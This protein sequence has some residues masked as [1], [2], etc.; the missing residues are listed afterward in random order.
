LEKPG[1]GE[2]STLGNRNLVEED[3]RLGA[4]ESFGIQHG[5]GA[6]S[7]FLDRLSSAFRDD[8]TQP[9]EMS[10]E[11]VRLFEVFQQQRE[12]FR[13]RLMDELA[14]DLANL[15]EQGLEPPRYPT[16]IVADEYQDFTAGELRLLALFKDKLGTVVAAAG[17][18]RQSIFGFRAADPLALHRFPEAYRLS[19][20]DYLPKSKRCPDA[21]CRFAEAISSDLPELPGIDRPPLS[22]WPGREDPGSVRVVV[23]PSPIGEARWIVSECRTLVEQG[24][25]PKDI[26]IVVSRFISEASA[27]LKRAAGEQEELPFSFY[28]PR[29]ADPASNDLAT[30]LASAAARL[31]V[32]GGDQMAWR[33]FVWATPQLGDAR[34]TRIL[35]VG[36]TDY[37]R[38]LRRVAAGDQ[39]CAR[40][41]TAGETVIEKYGSEEEFPALTAVEEIAS[42]LRVQDLDLTVLAGIVEDLAEEHS[43]SDWLERI[44]EVSQKTQ[45]DPEERPTDIAVRTIFSAKGLEAPVVFVTNVVQQ[46][47][48]GRGSVADG[49]RR[50][51][52][53]VTRPTERLYVS[54]PRYLGFSRMGHA[55]GSQTGGV[56]GA[57]TRAAERCE[58]TVELL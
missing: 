10:P 45:I 43:A 27:E 36:E 2:L 37:L 4:N 14:Y 32:D 29:V 46:S 9:A 19:E 13:Y 58:L 22:P 39:T 35:S 1:V 53:A 57:V 24:V 55:V 8:Q 44:F 34:K 51:Y 12:L 30:R 26:M 42:T 16:H 18:D 41:L 47:L 6:V 38:N 11:E 3:L 54:A 5:V 56:A 20:V 33:T 21:V 7:D 17:D 31:V 40:P 48:S 25:K 15:I 49:L 50:L 28:D 52:V 23:C